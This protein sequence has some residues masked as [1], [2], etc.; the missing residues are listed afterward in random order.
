MP[1]EVTR[2]VVIPDI[3]APLHDEPAVRCALRAIEVAKP[4][5][6]IMLGDLGEF[7][8]ASHWQWK[9]KKRPPLEYQLEA[10]DK[11]I[12]D[13]N[14]M[15]DR[16]DRVA[17]RVKV[18]RKEF[19]QGNHDE[20]LDR[21]VEENPYLERTRHE[22]GQGYLFRHAV[23]LHRRGWRYHQLNDILKIGHLRFCHGYAVRGL[24]HARQTLIRY[25]CNMIYGDKHDIQSASV[26]HVDGQKEAICVGCLKRLDREANKWLKGAP[27]NWG[28]A[29]ATV[30]WVG[31]KF[32]AQVHRIIDGCV[33]FY[34]GIID[35]NEEE[36]A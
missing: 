28:H 36:A 35:G 27:H 14:D 15:L 31:S 29:F 34:G 3:H 26:T 13:A 20:W 33:P 25:G 1:N 18:K 22:Y 5:I 32:S 30:D 24:H 16:F 17:E 2:A 21:L 23:G 10:I 11:D 12:A 8:G 7:E 9:K 4:D 6:L 19:L